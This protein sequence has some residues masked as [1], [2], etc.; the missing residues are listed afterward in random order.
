MIRTVWIAALCLAVLGGLFATRVTAS[1]A[2]T[3]EIVLH[4][5]TVSPSLTQD[6]LTKSDRFDLA[7]PSVETIPILPSKSTEVLRTKP[8]ARASGNSRNTPD[9]NANRTGVMLP[10]PRPKTRLSKHNYPA[11]A[12]TDLK[13]CTQPD[14][15]ADILVLLGGSR[16]CA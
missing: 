16:R 5:T 6:T 2:R 8:A 3:E 1:L 10:K 4:P 11:K 9:P 15:S 13:T 14:G 7:Y 12:V